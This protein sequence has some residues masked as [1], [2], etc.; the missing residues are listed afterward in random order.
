MNTEPT[1]AGTNGRRRAAGKDAP[2]T[3]NDEG[4]ATGATA[5]ADMI[6]DSKLADAI[7]KGSKKMSDLKGERKAI[8]ED[9]TATLSELQAKGLSRLAIKHAQKIAE[10]SPE[11]RNVYDLSMLVLRRVEACQ[12][13]ID[14]FLK[15]RGQ[16]TH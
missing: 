2:D 9:I 4:T 16:E 12:P 3:G 6:N 7:R 5:L 15:D 14:M 1:P 11:D 8:N 10:L 13:Q